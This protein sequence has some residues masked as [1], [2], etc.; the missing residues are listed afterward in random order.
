[1]DGVHVYVASEL[2]DAVAAFARNSPP[3]ALTQLSGTA[4]C[5]SETGTSG[6][7]ADG[8]ALDGAG[9]IAVSPD[10][11]TVYATAATSDAV[12]VLSR[13]PTTGTLTQLSGTAGCTSETGTSGN[14]A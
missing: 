9:G 5:V 2:S 6:A 8:N 10:G 11:T 1:P 7:C 12:A 13:N 4:G 14:C 3:G